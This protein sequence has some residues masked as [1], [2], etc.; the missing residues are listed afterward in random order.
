MSHVLLE[1]GIAKAK[2]LHGHV[3]RC[4]RKGKG[5]SEKRV[6]MSAR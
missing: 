4:L 2:A 3:H 6:V 5:E 1:E